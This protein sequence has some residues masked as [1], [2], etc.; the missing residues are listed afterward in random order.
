M[1]IIFGLLRRFT[2]LGIKLDECATCGAVCQHVVGRKTTWGHVFWIPVLFLGFSH[3][4][5]CSKCGASTQ[6]KWQSVRSGMKTGSL[7]PDRPRPNA[8]A[9]LAAAAAQEG[10]PPPNPATVFDRLHVNPKRGFWDL[11]LK[12]WPVLVAGLLVVGAISPRAT[13]A[14]G[15]GGTSVAPPV[16]GAAHQ[17]WEASDGSINGCRMS[18]GSVM[19]SASGTQITCYFNEPLPATETTLSCQ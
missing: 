7:P 11:Y 15:S 1:L 19:G 3:H 13:T 12:A 6:L 18:D 4:L 2:V 5:I 14:T 17:C 9:L 16:Y 8:P 10:T